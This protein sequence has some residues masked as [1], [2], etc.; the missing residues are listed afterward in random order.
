L[1]EGHKLLVADDHEDPGVRRRRRPTTG[2]GGVSTGVLKGPGGWS[3]LLGS[4]GNW[5]IGA[6]ER[7]RR[8]TAT[9]VRRQERGRPRLKEDE[10]EWEIWG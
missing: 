2:Q 10:D 8:R 6:D 3:L 1:D 4:H 7:V 5:K 9:T